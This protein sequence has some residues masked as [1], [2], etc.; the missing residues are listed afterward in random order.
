MRVSPCQLDQCS[1]LAID[2]T[3][4]CPQRYDNL[5]VKNKS[6]LC[7]KVNLEFLI[8]SKFISFLLINTSFQQQEH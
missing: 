4:T 1:V 7:Q 2:L 5:I 6:R 3:S 8:A